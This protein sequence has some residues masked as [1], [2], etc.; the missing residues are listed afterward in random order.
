MKVYFKKLNNLWECSL[1]RTTSDK[2]I[3][4]KICDEY[5]F[6][7]GYQPISYAWL[8]AGLLDHV[9]IFKDKNNQRSVVVNP[10]MDQD[11][12]VVVLKAMEI[13]DKSQILGAGFWK[14]GTTAVL[15]PFEPVRDIIDYGYI[16][17]IGK[18][19]YKKRIKNIE[20]DRLKT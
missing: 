6:V 14:E 4:D 11:K 7:A 9:F 5:G 10:Y 20:R 12:I 2:R 8:S 17:S 13:Y 19:E 3:Y 16:R 1:G 18:E 15:I